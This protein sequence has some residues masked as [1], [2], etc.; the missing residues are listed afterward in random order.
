[1]LEQSRESLLQRDPSFCPWGVRIP[2]EAWLA[3]DQIMLGQAPPFAGVGAKSELGPMNGH[4]Y[5]SSSPSYPCP[6]A[7]TLGLIRFWNHLKAQSSYFTVHCWGL[8]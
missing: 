1:M 8:L 4:P 5:P 7:S 3:R 2:S 6:V